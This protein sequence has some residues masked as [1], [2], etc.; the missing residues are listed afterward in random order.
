MHTAWDAFIMEI[1]QLNKSG[2]R[3]Y[4]LDSWDTT[5]SVMSILLSFW[6]FFLK[7][8]FYAL[9]LI[10]SN[11]FPM[12]LNRLLYG[13][14][15]LILLLFW[16]VM[17]DGIRYHVFETLS[18]SIREEPNFP[19]TSRT[20][21]LREHFF[22]SICQSLFI[23]ESFGCLQLPTSLLQSKFIWYFFPFDERSHTQKKGL[24]YWMIHHLRMQAMFQDLWLSSSSC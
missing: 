3:C 6:P 16:L 20:I 14:F 8:P 1:G 18:S 12:F 23:W 2:Q 21:L 17:F 10:V 7:D 15:L 4:Y 5:V 9:E 22:D 19:L 11:W 24:C 13:S